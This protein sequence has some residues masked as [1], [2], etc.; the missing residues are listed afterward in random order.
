[1]LLAV[2]CALRTKKEDGVFED[3]RVTRLI[4]SGDAKTSICVFLDDAG[5]GAT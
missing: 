2:D 3:T 5:V 1:M 4:E